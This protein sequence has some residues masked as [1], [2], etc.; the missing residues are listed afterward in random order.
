MT[1]WDKGY[2]LDETVARFTVQN[3]PVLDRRLVRY[4]CRASLVHAEMLARQGLLSAAELDA[5]RQALAEIVRQDEQGAFAIRTAD[6]DV[7]TAIERFLTERCGEAGRKIH[8]AR[9]RNDQVLT[10]IRLYEKHELGAIRQKLA[11]FRGALAELIGRS[12]DVPLPGYTHMRRAM[13]ASVALWLG[14]FVES[15]FD[16][17]RLLEATLQLV[18]QSP[19]GTA[20][21]FG[22]PLIDVDRAGTAR[23]LGFARVQSNPLYAQL[24]RGKLESTVVHLC[25]Q[26]LFDLN[27]LASDLILFGMTE[28]GFVVLPDALCTGSSIMPQ[29]KNPDVLELVRAKYHVVLGEEAKLKGII[30]NLMSG[31]HRD[32][33]LT[34]EPLFV[35]IDSTEECLDVMAVVLGSIGIDEQ[36]CRAAMSDE[37]YATERAYALVQQGTPF[38]DAY[39]QIGRRFVGR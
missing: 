2:A 34:K 30:G 38:R 15:S 12:G 26:I 25:T 23:A 13:P 9:S 27:R 29:K 17:E 37:L 10:A 18:D 1:L 6:E 22:V 3:D 33:Q 14:C 5:L 21:G 32:L 16:D 39:R 19:L 7:H 28:L 4:D 36:R 24:S 31:Y 11:S 35:S 8:T 20:A